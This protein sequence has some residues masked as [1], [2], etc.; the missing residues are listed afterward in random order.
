[1]YLVYTDESGNTGKNLNDSQ[2]PVFLL[3]ALVLNEQQWFDIEKDFYTIK[4]SYFGKDLAHEYEIHAKDLKN[5]EGAFK[6]LSF[7][8]QLEFRNKMLDLLVRYQIK[9]FYRR[10]IKNRF[11]LFCQKR[12]G[13]HFSVNPVNPYIMALPFVCMEVDEYIRENSDGEKW[14]LIFDE[15]KENLDDVERSLRTLRLDPRSILKTQRLLEKGFFVDSKKSFAL[16][17]VD[18]AAYYL[19]KYEEYKWG[20]RV[21]PV[22][23]QTFAVLEQIGLSET[24]KRNQDVLDWVEANCIGDI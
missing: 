3:A 8:Q 23:M 14:M 6:Q 5:R 19:R 9:V 13:P 20:K 17:L 22:D 7:E 1:M 4:E 18:I 11:K 2:Q 16:Q 15:Q 10:I 12:Y 24:W 21:S